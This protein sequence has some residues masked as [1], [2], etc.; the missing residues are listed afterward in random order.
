LV[1][2][3]ALLAVAGASAGI[4]YAASRSADPVAAAT[5][6]PAGVTQVRTVTEVSAT[7]AST[8]HTTTK[9]VGKTS[10]LW[11]TT[12]V[13]TRV[14]K[15]RTVDP[16]ARHQ[17]VICVPG[18]DVISSALKAINSWA[19]AADDA[20]I[21]QQSRQGLNAAASKLER[22]VGKVS[23]RADSSITVTAGL[24]AAV[25]RDLADVVA[26]GG[27]S[28]YSTSAWNAAMIRE[29]W[30]QDG[31]YTVCNLGGSTTA[32]ANAAAVNVACGKLATPLDAAD[33]AL[34]AWRSS[35]GSA[36]AGTFRTR[37]KT[38]SDALVDIRDGGLL[39]TTALGYAVSMLGYW[40]YNLGEEARHYA[41]E[42]PPTSWV[43][44]WNK[45]SDAARAACS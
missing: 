29:S 3:V 28:S 17:A 2:G 14:T 15:V 21:A 16:L 13:T 18:G 20:S 40:Q 31:F 5:G 38:L 4:T 11:V 41:T 33:R 35:P 6:S 43:S 10:V 24:M 27:T 19:S 32:K 37:A 42:Q 12:R 7:T 22:L 45:A 26:T 39:Y 36:T 34:S 30:I 44:G 1:A 25:F 9:T 8:A 23:G